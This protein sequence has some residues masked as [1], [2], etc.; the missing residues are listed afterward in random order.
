MFFRKISFKR[1]FGLISEINKESNVSS[2]L[3]FL[4]MLWCFLFYKIGYLEYRVFGFVYLKGKSRSSFM[5]SKHNR[6]FVKTLNDPRFCFIFEDKAKFCEKFNDFVNRDWIDLR[7]STYE[8][9]CDFLKNKQIFFAKNVSGCGGKAVKAINLPKNNSKSKL[10]NEL[11]NDNFFLLEEA[12]SQNDV[13]SK[14][15]SSCINTVRI[16]TVLNDQKVLVMYSLVR[17]GDGKHEV[18]NVSSGGMYCPVNKNGLIYAKAFCDATGRYYEK[19]PLTNVLFSGF[20]IPFYIEAVDMVKRAAL[21]VP[22]VRYIGWDVAITPSGPILVEG[23]TIPGYDMCQNYHHLI[24]KKEGIL[25]RFL[26]EVK[27]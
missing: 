2:F 27:F 3:V 17:I 7:K 1:M 9:Y 21:L 13:M 16:V 26:N 15:C 20:S 24:D 6:F 8:E 19:H 12:I 18:D 14:L 25:G 4:D 23:N 5:T 11:L 10:F 22:Q